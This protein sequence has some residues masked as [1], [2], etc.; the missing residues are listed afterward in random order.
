MKRNVISVI[1]QIYDPLGFLSPVTIRFKTLMQ[2]LCKTKVGWEQLLEGELL[3]KWHQ[4]VNDLK[5]SQPIVLPTSYFSGSKDEMT[6]YHL[7]GFCDA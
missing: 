5:T 7:Y 1:G 2:E 6:N 4:L 3:N